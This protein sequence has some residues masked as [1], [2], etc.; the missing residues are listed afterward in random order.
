M[1]PDYR[2]KLSNAGL[3]TFSWQN[4]DFSKHT[5][6]L[7]GII[8]GGPPPDGIKPIDSP[9][10]T[11]FDAADKW[12]EPLEPVIAL[13]LNGDARAY[14]LQMM[15]WNEIAN[16]VVGGV[17]VTI[18]FC[19]LCNSALTFDRRLDGIIYD[20]GTSGLLR[21][22]NLVMYDRQTH[23][24][25]Q[26]FTG[27]SI[28]GSQAG[29]FLTMIPASLISWGDFKSSY[30][31]G[32]VLSRD[33][34]E[35]RRYGSNPYAGYDRVYNPSFLYRGDLDGRLL[36][37]E[38]VAAVAIAGLDVAYPFSVLR[39]L[40]VVND[41]HAGTD[42][43]IFF[44]PDTLSALDESTISLSSSTGA[45]GV[46]LR[47]LDGPTLVF[48][49]GGNRFIDAETGTTWD[50]TGRGINGLLTGRQLTPVVHA[51]HFWFAWAAFKPT[52]RVYRPD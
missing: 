46:F 30:P 7:Q 34:G 45:T 18:T 15:T 35:V 27:E 32:S 29:K 50:I 8:S 25:W 23:S 16:D 6:P 51:N 10:F 26:Q 37:K 38:R 5:V 24:W 13:E 11:T 42:L 9:K 48:S 20:F 40:Q 28:V 3:S 52:T 43:V 33:T 36:P 4:T 44:E 31:R 12:L 47:E 49:P 22:S 39:T 21:N 41:T 1:D 17:P 19:P 2:E 14:P